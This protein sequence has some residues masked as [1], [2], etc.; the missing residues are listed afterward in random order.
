MSPVLKQVDLIKKYYSE[1]EPVDSEAT[2]ISLKNLGI[3]YD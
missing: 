3:A 1:V 2:S